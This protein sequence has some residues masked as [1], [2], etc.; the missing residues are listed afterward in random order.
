MIKKDNFKRV[1]KVTYAIFLIVSKI[2]I[3]IT[4]RTFLKFFSLK[5]NFI[6]FG[7]KVE[8]TKSLREREKERESNLSRKRKHLFFQSDGLEENFKISYI[9]F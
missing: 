1:S 7:I 5:R 2:Q 6:F 9:F 3:F 4:H 8:S